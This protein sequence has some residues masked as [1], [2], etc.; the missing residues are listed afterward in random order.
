MVALRRN[1]LEW[2]IS[3]RE[4]GELVLMK[5]SFIKK[6]S[7][8]SGLGEGFAALEGPPLAT[9]TPRRCASQRI[10]ASK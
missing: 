1:A 3:P 7:P 5:A 9:G 2:R 8:S 4:W 10:N 6:L